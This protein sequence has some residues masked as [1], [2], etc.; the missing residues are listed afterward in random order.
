MASVFAELPILTT[1]SLFSPPAL[2]SMPSLDASRVRA[3]RRSIAKNLIELS[4]TID[5]SPQGMKLDFFLGANMTDKTGPGLLENTLDRLEVMARAAKEAMATSPSLFDGIYF[6]S[7]NTNPIWRDDPQ[8]ALTSFPAKIVSVMTELTKA[9]EGPLPQTCYDAA[10]SVLCN[11]ILFE[12]DELLLANHVQAFIKYRMD[13]PIDCRAQFV[14]WRTSLQ[15]AAYRTEIVRLAACAERTRN[16]DAADLLLSFVMEEVRN[17]RSSDASANTVSSGAV[18]GADGDCVLAVMDAPCTAR[19]AIA[20]WRCGP[21]T[22]RAGRCPEHGQYETVCVVLHALTHIGPMSGSRNA[23][24]LQFAQEVLSEECEEPWPKSLTQRC[25]CLALASTAWFMGKEKSGCFLLGRVV[26]ELKAVLKA[27]WHV[28]CSPDSEGEGGR[29]SEIPKRNDHSLGVTLSCD[30]EQDGAPHWES[31]L[32]AMDIL[33]LVEWSAE[34]EGLLLSL[35]GCEL[36]SHSQFLLRPSQEHRLV[37]MLYSQAFSAQAFNCVREWREY[38]PR[39]IPQAVTVPEHSRPFLYADFLMFAGTPWANRDTPHWCSLREQANAFLVVKDEGE[40]PSFPAFGEVLKECDEKFFEKHAASC[41]ALAPTNSHV[42]PLQPADLPSVA[43]AVASHVIGIDVNTGRPAVRHFPFPLF[44]P[45]NG[46][47][48]RGLS[49]RHG[50]NLAKMSIHDVVQHG[51]RCVDWRHSAQQG[52][53]WARAGQFFASPQLDHAGLFASIDGPFRAFVAIRSEYANRVI[54]HAGRGRWACEGS[55]HAVFYDPVPL[56]AISF[57][58]AT[59]YCFP[60]CNVGDAQVPVFFPDET[61]D[62]TMIHEN[63]KN[64]A[65]QV[66][67]SMGRDILSEDE[68]IYNETMRVYAGMAKAGESR[69]GFSGEA[70]ADVEMVD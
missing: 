22:D 65:V 60:D 55:I 38:L 51:V 64:K 39:V 66:A 24:F 19:M 45:P 17:L 33:F 47:V 61:D 62:A 34:T 35:G 70:V 40:L 12:S 8:R 11:L 31:V 59:R 44:L 49:A 56:C 27:S 37:D 52:Q 50:D 15:P 13:S 69:R 43:R 57:V 4:K 20:C 36:L 26:A 67:K 3:K 1:T 29:P 18:H 32:R 14:S 54:S 30:C 5:K 58:V 53:T 7:R 10:L 41:G 25:V 6:W 21:C 68:I 2:S 63:L 28:R 16:F 48:F 42:R 23:E 46:L 9:T